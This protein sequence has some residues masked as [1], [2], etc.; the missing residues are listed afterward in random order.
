MLCKLELHKLATGKLTSKGDSMSLSL[1]FVLS[2]FPLEMVQ[3]LLQ[4]NGID[5]REVKP[6]LR[7]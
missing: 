5:Y 7:I 4:L 2:R 1:N 3:D 6:E